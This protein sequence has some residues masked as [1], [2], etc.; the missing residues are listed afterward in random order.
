MNLIRLTTTKGEV[1]YINPLHVTHFKQ[2]RKG[3]EIY[4]HAAG[5]HMYL[6]YI[7]VSEPV[8][9]VAAMMSDL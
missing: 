7:E 6:M 9:Q 5:D 8:D 3:T 2:T 1:V 4:F